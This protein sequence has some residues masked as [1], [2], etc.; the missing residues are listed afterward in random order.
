MTKITRRK[1]SRYSDQIPVL[2]AE[3]HSRNYYQALMHNICVDG[4]YFESDLPLQPNNELYLKVPLHRF[5]SFEADPYKAFR[6][7]VKWSR[8]VK[9]DKIARFGSGVQFAAKS[10]LAYGINLPN[11]DYSCDYCEDKVKDRRIHQTESGLQLCQKC[12][13]Y[14]ETLPRFLE[15]AVERQL[16]GNVI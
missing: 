16:L 8:Q 1:Y 2:L 13:S 12:L 7:K 6:A 11:S 3:Y 15:N 5:K 9:S 10:H 14:M 4:M